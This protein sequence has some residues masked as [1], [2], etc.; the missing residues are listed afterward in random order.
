MPPF[1]G[2]SAESYHDEGLTASMRGDLDAA[3]AAFEKALTFDPRHVPSKHQIAKCYLRKGEVRKAA[4]ILCKIAANRPDMLPARVD[5][6]F[7][8]LELNQVAGARTVF[9][10]L[11]VAAP[12]NARAHLGL[13]HCAFCEGQW[14]AC[15]E[16]TQTAITHGG[17]TFG[18]LFLLGRAARLAGRL[19]ISADAFTKA[20][21]IIEKHIETSPD[22]PEG[23][24]LRGELCYHREDF[25]KALDNYRSAEDRV[26]AGKQYLAFGERFSLAD[27]IAKR[28]LCYRGLGNS[29]AARKAGK[30]LLERDPS[31]KIG[32]T[33]TEA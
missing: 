32:K 31:S 28:G 14:D 21:E 7:A 13:A 26:V 20:D 1:G 8:L 24:Y 4:D 23:Y 17:A 10:E 6:G 33:L 9:Q 30:E 25:G 12:D 3:I 22:H 2:E 18:A 5:Y 19:D 15:V 11:I 16:L 27:I 29:D